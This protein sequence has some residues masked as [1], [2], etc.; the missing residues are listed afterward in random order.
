MAEILH[1]ELSFA[2]VGAAMEVHG[3]LGPGFLESVYH[4]ALMYELGLRAIP[5]ESY[6]TLPVLYKGQPV[7]QYEADIVVEQTIILELKAVSAISAAHIAQAHPQ[8]DCGWQL[9]SILG[10]NRFRLSALSNELAGCQNRRSK[11]PFRLIRAKRFVANS[12]RIAQ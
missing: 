4:S 3:Q 11:D 5:F 7:G 6:K 10:L 9:S 1:K 12:F 2:V 8:P